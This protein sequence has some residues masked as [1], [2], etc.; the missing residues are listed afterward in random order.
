[1]LFEEVKTL[2][3]P[4]SVDIKIDVVGAQIAPGL[5]VRLET[6]PGQTQYLPPR[7]VYSGNAVSAQLSLRRDIL[8][9]QY[10][11]YVSVSPVSQYMMRYTRTW[12]ALHRLGFPEIDSNEVFCNMVSSVALIGLFLS[13]F[14]SV[15]RRY[16]GRTTH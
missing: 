7:H 12:E 13:L 10:P 8:V 4:H 3:L 14:S 2:T 15:R 1:M 6:A 16:E 5:D 11:L 9:G